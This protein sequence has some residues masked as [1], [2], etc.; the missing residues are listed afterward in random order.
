MVKAV[1]T[2]HWRNII[3]FT[4]VVEV[5]DLRT[6][7]GIARGCE[8]SRVGAMVEAVIETSKFVLPASLDVT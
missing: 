3:L 4:I 7:V 8:K 6:I 1:V 5:I 2:N